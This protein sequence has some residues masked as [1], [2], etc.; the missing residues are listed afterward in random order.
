MP[1]EI[2][3]SAGSALPRSTDLSDE[4]RKDLEETKQK[5][6]KIKTAWV[7]NHGPLAGNTP[8]WYYILREAEYY[9]TQAKDEGPM[10][11]FGGQHLGPVGSHIV[12]ETFV[13]LLS[14]DRNSYLNRWP[15]FRPLP[16]IAPGADGNFSLAQLITYAVGG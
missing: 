7:D 8:L 4:A 6:A 14:R 13:G 5:R 11:A 12:A 16:P 3:W 15:G 1:A 9:G 10:A 2:L